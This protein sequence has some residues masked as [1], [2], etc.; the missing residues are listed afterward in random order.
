MDYEQEFKQDTEQTQF[1]KVVEALQK[2]RSQEDP[3]L[4]RSQSEGAGT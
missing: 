2:K 1:F 4:N 3:N